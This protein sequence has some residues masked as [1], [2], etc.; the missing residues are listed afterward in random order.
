MQTRLQ[1]ADVLV[2]VLCAVLALALLLVPL[3]MP[4]SQ[5]RLIVTDRQGQSRV[6]SL[7][8]KATLS[9]V[10]ENGHTLTVCI[11]NGRAFVSES[12]CPDGLCIAC[13]AISRHGETVVCLPAGIVLRIQAGKEGEADAVLG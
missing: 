9:L 11:D 3:L 13:G 5:A 7:T 12:S 10:G 8:Q 4:M 1:R 6:Y 2:M